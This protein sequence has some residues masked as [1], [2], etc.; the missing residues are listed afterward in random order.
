MPI[1]VFLM[2]LAAALIHATWNA[3]VKS[4][5]DRLALIKTL[6][7]THFIVSAGLLPFFA[8]P[9]L[10]SW[11]YLVGSAVL[12]LAYALL[13]HRA[14][15]LGDLSLVYP[16]AR[17]V[18]PLIVTIVTVLFLGE[19]LSR[20][21]Q[22]AVLLI[23][24]GIT[25]VAVARGHA[26]FRDPRPVLLAVGT[27]TFIAGYTILDGYGARIAGS[28]HSYVIW[29]SLVAGLLVAAVIHFMQRVQRA[30]I[31][32]RSRNAGIFSGLVSYL[33]SWLVIWSMTQAP[34]A[35]VSA[36][37]E[38]GIVLAVIIGVVFLK[39]RLSLIR[40]ASIAATLIG[41]TILKVNR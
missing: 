36:L 29:L 37:R 8:V 23:G 39:E 26:G 12:N 4:D 34:I 32:P 9:A 30:P 21:S 31:N 38:T 13:L 15:H 27:G 28:A 35:L 24:L 7:L 10:E 20:A 3:V 41:T 1:D 14:Y 40:I 33:A 18:A 19:Q 6:F 17:G 11:P 5:G 25:S 16:L 22:V 2:V